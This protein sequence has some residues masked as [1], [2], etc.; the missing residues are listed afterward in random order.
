M[1]EA[2]VERLQDMPDGSSRLALHWPDGQTMHLEARSKEQADEWFT[3]LQ[4]ERLSHVRAQLEESQQQFANAQGEIQDLKQQI[5]HYRHVEQDRDGALEDARKWKERFEELDEAIRLLGNHV[6]KLPCQEE[7]KSGTAE[8]PKF[9]A[10]T[11]SER[12]TGDKAA[13]EGGDEGVKKLEEEETPVKGEKP[14][15]GKIRA[16]KT[17][18]TKKEHEGAVDEGSVDDT[19]ADEDDNNK[20]SVSRDISLLDDDAANEAAASALFEKRN[21]IEELNAPGQHFPALL[22]ACQQLRENLR[23]ASEEAAAAVEDTKAAQKHSKTLQVRMTKAE[24][25]LCQLWEENCSIRKTLKQKKR[26]K[27]VLV[28]EVKSLME[29]QEQH[30]QQMLLQQQRLPLEHPQQRRPIDIEDDTSTLMGSDEERLINELEEHVVSSI[31]LNEELLS[32]GSSVK[33]TEPGAKLS[34][35]KPKKLEVVGGVPSSS[36]TATTSASTHSGLGRTLDRKPTSSTAT[37]AMVKHVSKQPTLSLGPLPHEAQIASLFDRSASESDTEADEGEDSGSLLG[38]KEEPKSEV[39]ILPSEVPAR[40]PSLHSMS[41]TGFPK[42]VYDGDGRSISSV[43]ASFGDS[44][45]SGEKSRRSTPLRPNPVL[46]LDLSMESKPSQENVDESKHFKPI[47]VAESGQA[48]S[49]LVCPLADVVKMKPIPHQDQTPVDDNRSHQEELQ[50]YHLTFYTR[51]IGLQFQ[52]V[53]APPTKSRGLLTDAMTAD[54]AG[55]AHG[56]S[57]TAAELRRVAA[58]STWAKSANDDGHPGGT[59]DDACLQV[60]TPIDAVLVCGFDGFDDTGNN[61]RPKLGARLVAFDGVSVEVGRWTFDSIR[62]AIQARGRPLTLSFRNDFLTTDQRTIMTKAVAKIEKDP[63]LAT[64]DA[65]HYDDV[66]QYNKNEASRVPSVPSVPSAPS[67]E[68]ELFVNETT[69]RTSN[70]I[71]L[72]QKGLPKHWEGE[73]DDLTVSTTGY[74]SSDH[75]HHHPYHR[76]GLQQRRMTGSSGS[77]YSNKKGGGYNSYRSFSEVGSSAS[78]LSSAIGPLMSNLM[79]GLSSEKKRVNMAPDYL[80]RRASVESTPQHQD[81]QSNLL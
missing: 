79:S 51:K 69:F 56:S 47:N 31:R 18:E 59:D 67:H 32:G 4:Q 72:H 58:I 61:V 50:I 39:N 73:D 44:T 30:Q 66:A 65:L 52:K 7:E 48:T 3:A 63:P 78:A 40:T 74:C 25:Q 5:N 12:D 43:N 1:D 45:C 21:I 71:S 16:E 77:Y 41:E 38:L 37:T 19:P 2:R 6:R 81:F 28:R 54:M 17:P 42:P 26:E 64:P 36:S 8:S 80:H 60:A 10:T 33:G 46:Q 55:E 49:R 29:Q 15:P 13:N 9:T 34:A 23:L 11:E 22:N 70:V 27:R 68:T 75:H 20:S 35:L 62:K 57:K 76:P 53:P 14:A 24:K